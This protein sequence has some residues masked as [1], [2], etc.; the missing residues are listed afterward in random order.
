MS[1][2]AS[3]KP[4]RRHVAL[5]R[6]INLGPSRSLP[7]KALA[8]LCT[9]AGCRDVQTYIQSGNVVFSASGRVATRFPDTLAAAILKK[10]KMEV[11]VVTR[12]AEELAR[13]VRDNPF[14]ERGI[15]PDWLHVAFLARAPA[16][17]QVA[18]LDPA[19]SPGD[20]FAV[21]GRDIYLH[22]PNGMART[23]LTN[24]YLDSRLKTVST[25]RNWRTVLKL[26]E[27][28]RSTEGGG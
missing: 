4:A 22:V 19:R 13:V 11:P 18:S 9:A 8:E 1:P 27:M 25:V 24:Q 20:A 2:R 28:A 16:L 17:E 10:F 5:L 21:V 15:D 26:L 6:G 12:S 7:M 23:K 3:G 14:L